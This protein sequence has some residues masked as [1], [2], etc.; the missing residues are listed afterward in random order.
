V[1]L[2]RAKYNRR[3]ESTTVESLYQHDSH[4]A[5]LFV[6]PDEATGRQAVEFEAEQAPAH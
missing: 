3:M 1:V 5:L 6:R 2:V 4:W